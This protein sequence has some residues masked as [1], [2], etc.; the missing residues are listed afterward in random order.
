MTPISRQH[1]ALHT[2]WQAAD[3]MHPSCR[4]FMAGLS[5]CRWIDEKSGPTFLFVSPGLHDCYHQPDEYEHHARALRHLVEHLS[6]LQQTVVCTLLLLSPC[7][8]WSDGS[9]AFWS[10]RCP[11]RRHFQ[12][13][14]ENL[15]LLFLCLQADIDPDSHTM[16]SDLIMLFET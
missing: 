14:A 11:W 5:G 7:K 13:C 3:T 6:I 12:C 10:L 16:Q 15:A 2:S 4:A 9:P 1:K 8:G